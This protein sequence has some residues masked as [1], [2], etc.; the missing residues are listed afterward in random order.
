[1]I[2]IFD[3]IRKYNYFQICYQ[4]TDQQ[5]IEREYASLKNIDDNFPKYVVSMDDFHLPTNE[6]IEHI[7]PWQVTKVVAPKEK[8]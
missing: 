5:T 3:S 7:T 6:G 4:L 2:G 1:M 8:A